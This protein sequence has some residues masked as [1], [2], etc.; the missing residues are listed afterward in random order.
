MVASC[1]YETF[2]TP[3]LHEIRGYLVEIRLYLAKT[4][5][6]HTHARTTYYKSLSYCITKGLTMLNYC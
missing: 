5:P 6:F 2:T 1:N 4:H 3:Y